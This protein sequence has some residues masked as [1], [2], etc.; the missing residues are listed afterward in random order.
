MQLGHSLRG[1][2]PT[3]QLISHTTKFGVLKPICKLAAKASGP[4]PLY[5]LLPSQTI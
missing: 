1:A 4:E 2:G 3:F 5:E